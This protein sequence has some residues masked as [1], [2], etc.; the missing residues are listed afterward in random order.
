[1]T[2]F[3]NDMNKLEVKNISKS[4]DGKPVLKDVSIELNHGE[5][6]CLLG[7]SGGGK[8]TICHLI[9]H[10]Y[11][12]TEGDITSVRR[13]LAGLSDAQLSELGAKLSGGRR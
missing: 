1:M 2:I 5:L 13:A 3:P 9:P 4:F 7:V 6:V 11:N 12:V 8:T 10:F